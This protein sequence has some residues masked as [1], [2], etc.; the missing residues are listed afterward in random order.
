MYLLAATACL[1]LWINVRP[2]STGQLTS[3]DQLIR[4]NCAYLLLTDGAVALVILASAGLFGS[5]ILR[6]FGIVGIG[7]WQAGLF[8]MG[9][10]ITTLSLATLMLGLAGLLQRWVFIALLLIMAAVGVVTIGRALLQGKTAPS[11]ETERTAIRWLGLAFIPLAMLTLVASLLPTGILWNHDGY[12]YD[13]LEYHLQLPREYCQAQ[14]ITHIPHNIFSNLPANA[15]MLYLV[16][17]V[18]KG[19]PIDGLYLAQILNY[20]LAILFVWGIY[21]I[22]RQRS[23]LGAALA[24]ATATTTQLF[25]VATNTY[26]ECYLL[27]M[28]LLAVGILIG[29]SDQASLRRVLIAGVFLGSACGAKYTAIVM[30]APV[31]IILTLFLNQAK[32]KSAILLL[33]ATTVVF[34]PWL[35]KNLIYT[36]NP[37]FPLAHQTLGSGSYSPELLE[38]WDKAT[39]PTPELSS[40]RVRLRTL[41]QNLISPSCYG[42]AVAVAILVIAIATV[43]RTKWPTITKIGIA[44]LILQLAVWT[45]LTH[46]QP[47]FL[48]VI[49]IPIAFIIVGIVEKLS[50]TW[51]NKFILA[52]ICVIVI[53]INSCI[54]AAYYEQNTQGFDPLKGIGRDDYTTIR[55]SFGL[56]PFA[57]PPNTKLLLVGE[58][59]PFYVRCPVIYNTVFDRCLLAEQLR[60]TDAYETIQW[61]RQNQI[62]HV[63]VNWTEVDRLRESYGFPP[64]I[65]PTTFLA[66]EGAG[67]ITQQ[68]VRDPRGNLR[69]ILYSIE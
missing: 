39:H 34:A 16:A 58:A 66:L 56:P 69:A 60:Q 52:F 32:I 42:P 3:E 12:G 13:S 27:L 43:R 17:M 37:I 26:V 62:T 1:A 2:L 48:L 11:D 20:C 45:T 9:I 8:G 29:N 50:P 53:G 36:G 67:I 41:T 65:N 51:P 5:A 47:R 49:L 40:P 25:F 4:L 21:V 55:Y 63:F 14:Q 22:F 6:W 30:A 33:L 61:L 35:I 18:L 44:S 23:R 68:E 24:A 59:R 19:G 7:P 54:A 38:R 10:G 46:L 57:I 15:E 64:E 28:F 31:V